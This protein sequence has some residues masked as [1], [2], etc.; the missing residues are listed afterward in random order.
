MLFLTAQGLC[1]GALSLLPFPRWTKAHELLVQQKIHK[2]DIAQIVRESEAMLRYGH[3][4]AVLR[5]GHRDV[6][7]RY[8]LAAHSP[9]LLPMQPGLCAVTT[10]QRDQCQPPSLAP[11]G[12]V[13]TKSE[14]EPQP[15]LAPWLEAAPF[16]L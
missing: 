13:L 3:G 11:W 5:F 4:D 16:L 8:S 9:S 1:L 6:M 14:H 10:P 15:E 7:L 12:W 2:S